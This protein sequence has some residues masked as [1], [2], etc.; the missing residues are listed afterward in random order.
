MTLFIG[1]LEKKKLIRKNKLHFSDLKP[2]NILMTK[3]GI[4]KIADF[5]LSKVIKPRES[6]EY[7]AY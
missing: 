7:F 2:A 4:L 5:G 1:M 3:N 6:K